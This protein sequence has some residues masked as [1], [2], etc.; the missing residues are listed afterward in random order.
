ML[1]RRPSVTIASLYQL[2]QTQ[3][4][5]QGTADVDSFAETMLEE[6]GIVE[7]KRGNKRRLQAVAT[8]LSANA[9][10]KKRKGFVGPEKLAANWGIGTETAKRTLEAST[11][12]AVR[13]FKHTTG[14]RRMKPN[15]WMLKYPRKDC[16]VYTDTMFGKVKSLRGNTCMQ[17]YATEFHYLRA[18]PMR[19]KSQAD[20]TLN[21]FFRTTGIPAGMIPD[22]AM[23]LTK[24]KF[25]KT[26]KRYQCTILPC[27]SYVKDANA[28]EDAIKELRRMFQRQMISKAVPEV[29]WDY[30]VEL[31]AL[32]RSMTALDI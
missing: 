18:F 2:R 29:L 14:G 28:A 30:C 25:L 15:A 31:C 10:L 22:N 6:M 8:S 13:D 23:E 21:E 11:Q 9:T 1:P 26:A 19:S 12:L 32:I 17:V 27:E 5:N 20:E 3:V 7:D 24:G 16:K 4:D